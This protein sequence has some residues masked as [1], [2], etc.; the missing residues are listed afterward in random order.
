MLVVIF[1][2]FP[3][4]LVIKIELMFLAQTYAFDTNQGWIA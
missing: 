1:I 4:A 2:I 3:L